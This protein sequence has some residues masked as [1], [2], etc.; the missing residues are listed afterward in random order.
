MG[1]DGWDIRR[2]PGDQGWDG[3]GVEGGDGWDGLSRLRGSPYYA[4]AIWP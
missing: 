2:N 4:G 3:T 1:W